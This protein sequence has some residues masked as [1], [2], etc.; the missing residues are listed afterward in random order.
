M[1]KDDNLIIP[2][3]I[4]QADLAA[5]WLSDAHE[6]IA[7]DKLIQ[8]VMQEKYPGFTTDNSVGGTI[9]TARDARATAFQT[10][11]GAGGPPSAPTSDAGVPGATPAPAS[12]M[13]KLQPGEVARLVNGAWRAFPASSQQA[14][15]TVPQPGTPPQAQSIKPTQ[16]G[17]SEG[18]EGAS[19]SAA[20]ETTS[21]QDFMK[22]HATD[23]APIKSQFDVDSKTM[24]N[25]ELFRK[26][27]GLKSAL[28]PDQIQRLQ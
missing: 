7:K 9:P 23:L 8:K 18:F 1:A 24:S 6:T 14:S 26:Y 2:P 10:K 19:S 11:G 16:A 3:V 25:K 21:I 22:Q 5:A 28:R 27:G 20:P 12:V 15:P 13:A 4:K 17:G